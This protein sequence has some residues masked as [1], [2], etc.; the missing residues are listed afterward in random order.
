M[1]T[2]KKTTPPFRHGLALALLICVSPGRA[3]DVPH[4]NE[5]L[6]TIRA[7]RHGASSVAP[8][9]GIN[10]LLSDLQRYG[11]GLFRFEFR[12]KL[13]YPGMAAGAAPKLAL[14]HAD[15]YRPLAVQPDGLIELPIIAQAQ[16]A[17]AVLV[18]D[19][20]KGNL[21]LNG[22]LLLTTPPNEL[23]MAGV[24]RI[25]AVSHKLRS[26]MLPWYARLLFPQVQGVEICS[27]QAGWTLQWRKDGQL[28]G[29]PLSAETDPPRNESQTSLTGQTGPRF[30]TVLTGQERWPDAA[31]LVAPPD[32]RIGVRLQ[33]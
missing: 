23:D 7:E 20:P 31:L 32:T 8:Y 25:M 9:S 15:F 28:W 13:K 19:Q 30:C 17:E 33:L 6:E 27:A 12:L 14:Q 24:R 18:S 26:E 2:M 16:A 10:S 4:A 29:V 1:T 21:T 3:Q 11:E 22:E 5:Q